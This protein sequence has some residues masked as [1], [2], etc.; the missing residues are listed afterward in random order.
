M[1]FR[2]TLIGLAVSV[3]V[4]GLAGCS[5]DDDDNNDTNEEYSLQLL[6]FADVDGAP[7]AIDEVDRF[8]ALVQ[9]F[10]TDQANTLLVSSGDNVIPGPR[11]FAAADGALVEELG[12]PGNGRADIAF[13]NA[14]GVLVSAIGNHDLDGGPEEFAS[15]LR[16]ETDEDDASLVYEGAAFPFVSANLDVTTEPALADLATGN[17]QQNSGIGGKIAG[18]TVVSVGGEQIGVVGATTPALASITSTGNITITPE[19]VA[20]DE[21]L[22]DDLA[23]EIQPTVDDL[24]DAG[25]NKIILVA[26]MQQ[27]AIEKALATRLNDVDVIVAGG[28]NT[29][30]ADADDVLRDGDVAA[31]TYP[32]SFESPDGEPVLV[33]NV[34][35][36]YKY[37]GRL[38][39]NF[40]GNGVIKTDE[41]DPAQNGAWASTEAIV[42]ELMGE[43]IVRV[44]EVSA[45]IRDVLAARDGNILGQTSVYLDGRRSEVRTE[46]TNLGN[47]SAEANLWYAKRY[48]NNVSVSLK[49]GGGIRSAIGQIV[50]PAGS[51][52]PADAEL[53]PPAANESVGKEEGDISQFDIEGSLRFNNSLA[54]VTVTGAELVDLMEY[55]VSATEEGATPGQ[56]PQI[57]GMRFSFDPSNTARATGDTNNGAGTTPSRIVNLVVDGGGSDV[58]LV[59]D[60]VLENQAQTF[61]LVT[62]GFLASCLP[63]AT[64]AGSANCGDGYPF[65]G[66]GGG[67]VERLELS[68]TDG[69][70]DPGEADFAAYGTEQDAIAE[71]LLASFP[72]EGT[73]F[74]N[75]AETEPANDERIQNLSVRSDTVIGITPP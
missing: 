37:L 24:V 33:V 75:N 64:E 69:S 49:N 15:M 54:I 43:P 57:A 38:V 8:S 6:H 53:E 61:E 23:A 16:P 47:L 3:A 9:A 13:M 28:S 48:D 4:A 55:A 5:D 39:L 34:D 11:Y 36:D 73:V 20:D 70:S 41:L 62:L 2:K 35:G 59:R 50:Q 63:T 56:F 12:V 60:G 58:V 14:M 65:K 32:L 21:Q 42:D 71:Y 19:I 27:I 17:G 1:A 52:D 22:Y 29:L 30:L 45:E 74:F 44:A 10:R 18:S 7:G 25:I 26:H 40:D 66:L 31:D 46:E 68:E 72:P 67:A 51:N